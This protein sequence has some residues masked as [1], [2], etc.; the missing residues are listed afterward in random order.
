MKELTPEGCIIFNVPAFE[1]VEA[2]FYSGRNVYQYLS[3]EVYH[4][5]KKAGTKIAY[6]RNVVNQEV[7]PWAKNDPDI[8]W[9]EM[10]LY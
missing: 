7:L 5:L 1:D 10:P 2:M 4:N 6:F 3:E 9:L 8:I